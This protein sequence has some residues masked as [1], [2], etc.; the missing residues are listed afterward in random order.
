MNTYT[1]NI[2]LPMTIVTLVDTYINMIPVVV[3]EVT[4][5]KAAGM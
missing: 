2:I 3:G 5:P 4:C 1:M